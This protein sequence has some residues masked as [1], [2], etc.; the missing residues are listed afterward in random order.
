M[1]WLAAVLLFVAGA[2]SAYAPGRLT[3][4]TATGWG[5]HTLSGWPTTPTV[6]IVSNLNNSGAG[7]LRAAVEGAVSNRIVIC[8]ISGDIE[9][10]TALAI[11]GTRIEIRL[12]TCP[13]EGVQL[14]PDSALPN[15]NRNLVSISGSHIAIVGM[16]VRHDRIPVQSDGVDCFTTHAG[17]ITDAASDIFISNS[18]FVW[19]SDETFSVGSELLVNGPPRV[20]IQDTIVGEPIAPT[21]PI[22]SACDTLGLGSLWLG[23]NTT[24][25]R[26]I[27]MGV[28]RLPSAAGGGVFDQ[29]NNL[30]YRLTAEDQSHLT[31][32]FYSDCTGNENLAMKLNLVGNVYT[33]PELI[34]YSSTV[35]FALRKSNACAGE[36]CDGLQVYDTDNTEL[37]GSN[38]VRCREYNTGCTSASYTGDCASDDTYD[39]TAASR[40]E[41]MTTVRNTL[42]ANLVEDYVLANAGARPLDSVDTCLLNHIANRTGEPNTETLG[43]ATGT[44]NDG[45]GP[46]DTLTG[47]TFTDTDT[48]GMDDE[49]ETEFWGDLDEVALG[50]LDGDGYYNVEEFA[51]GTHPTV[52]RRFPPSVR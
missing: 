34:D 37:T 38:E 39:I 26:S 3:I 27:W 20:T 16:R 30:S 40:S 14:V 11:S 5:A 1:R 31:T 2:A 33:G 10:E 25:T 18:S 45:C 4:P 19:G 42:A 24:W 50:D 47:A 32:T 29:R 43:A 51:N 8:N 48:D 6:F 22:D 7:S 12:D 36:G 44:V 52:W 9:L 46:K 21:D 28:E 17:A 41:E 15:N 49:W 35:T 23:T 13:G